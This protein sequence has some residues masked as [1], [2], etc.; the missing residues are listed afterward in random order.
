MSRI[1]LLFLA[2]LIGSL[3]SAQEYHVSPGGDDTNPGTLK[4]P[5]KTISRAA[6]LAGAGSVITVHGGIYREHVDPPRGGSSEDM[7]IIYQAA[8]GEKV[9]IKGSERINFWEPFSGNVWKAIIPNSFFGDYNPYRDLI[10]GDWFTDYGRDHHT[11]EVYLNGESMFEVPLLEQVLNPEP[12]ERTELLEESTYTWFCES[13]EKNTYI[14]AN[15]GGKDPNRELVEINV[16]K[17]CF[18]PTRTGINYIS[19]KGFHMSQAATQWAPPTAEQIGLI[20]TNWSKGWI[21]EDN[22][23]SHSKCT[24]ITL[25]KDRASG[26][27][28]WMNDPSI[29]GATHYNRLISKVLR[30]PY[31]WTKENIGSHI[32]RNNTIFKCEQAGIC[33][34]MGC[35]F[36]LVE[37]NHIYDIWT[38][39]QF[40]GAEIAGIKF[41]GPIDAVIRNNRIHNA[42]KGIWLDWMTQGTRVSGNLVYDIFSEDLFV[43]VNHGPFTIDNNLFLSNSV[44]ILDGSSGGAYIHNLVVGKLIIVQQNRATPFHKPHS[45]SVYGRVITRNA[46]NRYYNNVFSAVDEE[47]NR[48]MWNPWWIGR[49]SYGLGIYT[50]YLPMYTDGNAYFKG[51]EAYPDEENK[52][53]DPGFDPGIR[54]EEKGDE[55]YLHIKYP[56]NFRSLD[57]QLI[58]TELLGRVKTSDAKYEQPDG[59]PLAIDLD[60]LGNARDRAK[61]VSG[62]FE[63]SSTG[64]LQIRVW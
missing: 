19:V 4:K 52:I 48:A 7:R 23:I 41:H 62:P 47:T 11:G 1:N 43:E 2:V 6:E 12:L 32:V 13:D 15:F 59:S 21:I 61:P 27:N 39:R 9:T 58:T 38:K 54:V 42:L 56:E 28:I 17:A 46:D 14:Y 45:T 18:Y 5:L 29:D 36:S 63:I 31:N 26:Q 34:S 25:G 30:E 22:V 16:R 10:H 60:Y 35:A 50:G 57:T 44:S 55:V 20:G 33:G 8:E 51:A 64:E 40:A 49:G 24:G 3:A 53:Y 37:G